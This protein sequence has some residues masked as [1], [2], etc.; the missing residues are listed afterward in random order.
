MILTD[1]QVLFALNTRLFHMIHRLSQSYES[2]R[3]HFAMQ[4][5]TLIIISLSAIAGFTIAV[6]LICCI[7]IRSEGNAD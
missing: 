4:E 3:Y 5:T 7:C 1:K 6:I 2:S